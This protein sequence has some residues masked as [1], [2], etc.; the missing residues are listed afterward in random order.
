MF[1][2]LF[3]RKDKS[4]PDPPEGADPKTETHNDFVKFE[5]TASNNLS[6][7]IVWHP[8]GDIKVLTHILHML[9][10]G[11]LLEY[12]IDCIKHYGDLIGRPDQATMISNALQSISTKKEKVKA[13]DKPIIPASK[14]ISYHLKKYGN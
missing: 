11:Q 5:I 10:T 9:N 3:N 14:V 7:S 8:D 12:Q 1:T 6:I 4:Q 2:K 13:N